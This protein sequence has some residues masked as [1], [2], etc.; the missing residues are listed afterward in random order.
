MKKATFIFAFLLLT[1]SCNSDNKIK[2]LESENETLLKKIDSL[3]D[4]FTKNLSA[5]VINNNYQPKIKKGDSVN[6]VIALVYNNSEI[7][8]SVNL[9]LYDR[10]NKLIPKGKFEVNKKIENGFTYFNLK[11]LSEGKYV[12]SG[13]IQYRNTKLPLE[14]EFEIE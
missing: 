4:N 9:N 2:L 12:Y 10:K 11:K 7:I 5:I 14:Y 13:N 1:C 8:D 3:E 6:F